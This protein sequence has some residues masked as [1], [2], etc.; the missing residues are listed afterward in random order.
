M[1]SQVEK[2]RNFEQAAQEVGGKMQ[3]APKTVT[4]EVCKRLL[5]KRQRTVD[6]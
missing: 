4:S 1:Q 2:Q 5:L 6:C 3:E